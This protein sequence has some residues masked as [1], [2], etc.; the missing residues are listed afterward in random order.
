MHDCGTILVVD[1][2]GATRAA[3]VYVATR[4]GYQVL[5]L[6]NAELAVERLDDPAPALAIVEV[7]LPGPTSGLELL[8]ELH[9]AYGEDL[10]V[11]LVSA[12]RKAPLDHVAG[13][14]IG[15]DDY[16]AKPLDR[17]ELLARVRRSLRRAGVRDCSAKR[18]I[19]ARRSSSR[20]IERFSA[21]PA[22]P[23]PTPLRKTVRSNSSSPL[24]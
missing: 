22:L 5:A 10:P 13:L 3:A 2:D 17:G 18:R 14:M 12:E 23:L 6:E 4:L 1:H 20:S 7:E 19:T 16:M 21:E 9:A 15:A 24:A 11:I 8:R